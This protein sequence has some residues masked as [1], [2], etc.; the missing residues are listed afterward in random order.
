LIGVTTREEDQLSPELVLAIINDPKSVGRS[1]KMPAYHDKLS[2]AEKQELV[3]WIRSLTPETDN[4]AEHTVQ[5]AK[6]DQNK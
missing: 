5:S 3:S 6:L 2:E 4:T 1:T